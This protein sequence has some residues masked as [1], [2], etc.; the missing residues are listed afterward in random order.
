MN[1][2][3]KSFIGFLSLCLR[4]VLFKRYHLLRIMKLEEQYFDSINYVTFL[5]SAARSSY[6]NI[7]LPAFSHTRSDSWGKR[8]IWFQSSLSPSLKCN[9]WNHFGSLEQ[10]I[11]VMLMAGYYKY[12]VGSLLLLIFRWSS[13]TGKAVAGVFISSPRSLYFNY[14]TKAP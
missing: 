14:A 9:S 2:L 5:S 4:K 12:R 11:I 6:E 13:R 7:Q 8:F 1:P 10:R 3:F